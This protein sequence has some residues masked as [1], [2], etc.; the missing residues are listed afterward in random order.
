MGY[1]E[2]V[3]G[4]P[5]LLVQEIPIETIQG[6]LPLPIQQLN[7]YMSEQVLLGA[8]FGVRVVAAGL[9]SFWY[10]SYIRKQ[11]RWKVVYFV[12]MTSLI[13]L[14]VQSTLFLVSMF[15]P[16][17]YISTTF[18][19]NFSQV[20]STDVNV[21]VAASLIQAL[22]VATMELSFAIQIYVTMQDIRSGF[23]LYIRWALTGIAGILGLVTTG[24]YFTYA[25]Q[26]ISSA[27]HPRAPRLINTKF[28]EKIQS[29]SQIVF[30]ASC[31]LTMVFLV[32]KF[33][34]AIR[35]RRVLGNK[36]FGQYEILTIMGVQCMIIP[37]VITLVSFWTVEIG[38]LYA[39]ATCL[40]AISLPLSSIWAGSPNTKLSRESSMDKSQHIK[41][42]EDE[43]FF[44]KSKSKLLEKLGRTSQ[45]ES[46]KSFATESVVEISSYYSSSPT[47]TRFDPVDQQIA[48]IPSGLHFSS[49]NNFD[50][51]KQEPTR[52]GLNEVQTPVVSPSYPNNNFESEK[53]NKHDSI[54]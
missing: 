33:V 5:A 34:Y 17:F 15:S 46:G 52:V 26:T 40:V 21:T 22:F 10:F 36:Q 47:N 9:T 18:T 42:S 30:T 3:Y 31:I 27:I 13:L 41:F 54:V 11:N 44:S 43:S 16:F 19:G 23:Y 37:S 25:S 38:H 45:R 35:K 4:D 53:N 7:E 12:N 20:T 28:G 51:G 49:V 24:F 29:I 1:E 2:Y 48:E 8:L 14:F 32:S 6:T 50:F 39:L